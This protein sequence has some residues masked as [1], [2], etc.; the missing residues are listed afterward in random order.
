MFGDDSSLYLAMVCGPVFV[1]LFAFAL[2][3]L[4]EDSDG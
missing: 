3:N 4:P 2:I 1:L